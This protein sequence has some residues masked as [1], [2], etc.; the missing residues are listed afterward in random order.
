MGSDIALDA[1]SMR[2]LSDLEREAYNAW[3][4]LGFQIPNILRPGQEQG[5]HQQKQDFVHHYRG[6]G[7]A[8]NGEKDEMWNQNE[9]AEMEKFT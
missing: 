6:R 8:A 2:F 1:M 7:N 3:G 9:Q 4:K 5:L